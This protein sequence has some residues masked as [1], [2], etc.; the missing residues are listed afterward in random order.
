MSSL[1][2]HVTAKYDY[3]SIWLRTE[4]ISSSIFFSSLIIHFFLNSCYYKQWDLLFFL[5]TPIVYRF[6]KQT[7]KKRGGMNM[8]RRLLGLLRTWLTY[9]YI[10]LFRK[11]KI[12]TSVC[13]LVLIP[14]WVYFLMKDVYVVSCFRVSLLNENHSETF[15]IIFWLL[16]RMPLRLEPFSE[17]YPCIKVTAWHFFHEHFSYCVF[18][19][20]LLMHL[21][22]AHLTDYLGSAPWT[23]DRLVCE[24]LKPCHGI[25]L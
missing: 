5:W 14:E 22:T 2:Q 23:Y 9:I 21:V 24:K 8:K 13:H 15:Y 25:S 3:M 19:H 18:S 20:Y 17:C 12:P 7:E 16:E 11:R 4:P 10:W 1:F 6:W